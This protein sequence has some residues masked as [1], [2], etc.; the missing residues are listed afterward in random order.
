MT[1]SDPRAALTTLVAAFERHLEAAAARRGEND[2]V[3]LSAYRD[4][5]E[6]FEDYDDALLEAFD[7]VTPFEIFRDDDT[8][9]DT[10]EDGAAASAADAESADADGAD[11]DDD[12]TDDDDADDDET[13]AGTVDD[14]DEPDDRRS[15]GSY[16]G[17][18][19]EDYD[20]FDPARD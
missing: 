1:S 14:D 11:A 3:V 17:L 4:L 15:T 18:D 8:D 10:D 19:D 6:A 5:S 16:T 12:E 20:E 13:D 2:P 9:D 7:E